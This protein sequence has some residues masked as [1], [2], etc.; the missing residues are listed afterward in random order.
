M[1][2]AEENWMVA[3]YNYTNGKMLLLRANVQFNLSAVNHTHCINSRFYT[4]LVLNELI[5][6]TPL[7]N[8]A[9]KYKM[10]R[11]TLQSL[12]QTTSTFA[13]IVKSFCN[14]L[15]W[16]MLALIV[17]QFQDRIFFGV[18]QDLI[19]LMKISVL[20]GQRA[21]ALFNAGYKTL[22]DISK[23]NTLDIEKCLTD[24]ISFDV[25]KRDGETNYDAEQRNKHRLLFVTGRAGLST[26]EASKLIIDEA[27]EYLSTEMGIQN[28]N[29]SQRPEATTENE[30]PSNRAEEVLN[31]N[32][33]IG[34]EVTVTE[35]QALTST[36]STDSAVSRERQPAQKRRISVD[37]K[38]MTP[39]KKR[40]QGQR[41]LIVIQ[42]TS[43]D[44]SSDENDD[45]ILD[46]SLPFYN[47][48]N[49]DFI[50]K[51]RSR[52]NS[53]V[54]AGVT[55]RPRLQI[56]DVTKTMEEFEKFQRAFDKISECGFSLATGGPDKPSSSTSYRCIVSPDLYLYGVAISFQDQYVTHFINLQDEDAVDFQTKTKFIKGIL[57][58]KDLTLVCNDSKTQLKTLL[59]AISDI[60]RIDCKIGDPLVAQWLIQPEESRLFSKMVETNETNITEY[61]QINSYIFSD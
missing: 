53:P 13:G 52:S 21:R 44:E 40:N 22:V 54:L 60:R 2:I 46:D 30:G 41:Q 33:V 56:I 4:A 18:H 27:R 47:N 15:N 24:S 34:V 61:Q 42:E 43:S 55:R 10:S 58:N 12:Q 3:R 48:E 39:S 35:I 9:V 5:N 20:N 51:I 29:W 49:D 14:A 28:I 16:D 26:K 36:E 23:A 38:V 17:S 25:Q 7:N 1:R 6:E 19:E 8:V 37:E 57:A 45:V 59:K 32:E 11:G 50:H 31:A